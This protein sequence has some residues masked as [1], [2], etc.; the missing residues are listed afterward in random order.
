MILVKNMRTKILLYTRSLIG[1][2]H[3]ESFTWLVI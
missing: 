3:F 2:H 1:A